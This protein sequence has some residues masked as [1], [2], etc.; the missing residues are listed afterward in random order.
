MT[1]PKAPLKVFCAG[2]ARSALGNLHQEFERQSGH[3]VE[4]TLGPVGALVERLQQG[5]EADV[6]VLALGAL[7]KLAQTG[8]VVPGS[9]EVVGS[10]RFAIAQARGA[11]PIQVG[12]TA[13]LRNALLQAKSFAY[14]DPRNGDTSGLHMA[15]VLDRLGIT[16]EIVPK[17]VL[18]PMGLKV[19]EAVAA[20]RAEIGAL[21]TSIIL[22]RDDLQLAG[23]LPDEHQLISTYAMAAVADAPPAALQLLAHLSTPAARAQF[24]KAGFEAEASSPAR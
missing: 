22:A 24:V 4:F 21:Q 1:S 14:G 12:S 6:L 9:I 7:K 3:A 19:A 2:A 8:A 17:T 10:V 16:E 15:D 18:E 11:A 20:G 23:A 13:D 5:E